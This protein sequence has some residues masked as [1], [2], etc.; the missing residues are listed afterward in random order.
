MR[1]DLQ[2]LGDCLGEF[3]ELMGKERFTSPKQNSIAECDLLQI[4][5]ERLEEYQRDFDLLHLR[6]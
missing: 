2:S 6:I 3:N 4:G 1:P 5:L